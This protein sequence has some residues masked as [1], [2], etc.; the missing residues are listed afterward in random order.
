[1][2]KV[3][4]NLTAAETRG[5]KAYLKEE[6]NVDRPNGLDIQDYIKKIV[7][8]KLSSDDEIVF[9]YIQRADDSEINEEQE[10]KQVVKPRITET[11]ID[12]DNKDD[13][14]EQEQPK[15]K[16]ESKGP[17]HK[18]GQSSDDSNISVCKKCYCTRTTDGPFK[19]QYETLNGVVSSVAPPCI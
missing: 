18:W 17:R 3:T 2:M 8:D 19:A 15:V 9:Q 11:T 6:E 7:S 13:D 14:E 16:K 4:I 12:D 1:M 5:I 10:V